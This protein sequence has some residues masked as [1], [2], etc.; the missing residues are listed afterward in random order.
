MKTKTYI[1]Y[2]EAGYIRVHMIQICMS[3]M[4]NLR[5]DEPVVQ[6]LG[7][8]VQISRVLVGGQGAGPSG[9]GGDLKM[10]AL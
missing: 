6:V 1:H 8:N 5:L 3:E 2:L 7:A 9:Q 10:H 4:T